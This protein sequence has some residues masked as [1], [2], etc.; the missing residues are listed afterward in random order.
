MR[1]DLDFVGDKFLERSLQI[2][3]LVSTTFGTSDQLPK[4][5]KKGLEHLDG[6]DN[7][8]KLVAYSG[9]WWR[10]EVGRNMDQSIAYADQLM[11]LLNQKDSDDERHKEWQD[12][13]TEQ[14]ITEITD[15]FL[16]FEEA[17]GAILS[18]LSKA[19]CVSLQPKPDSIKKYGRGFTYKQQLQSLFTT[20]PATDR[21]EIKATKG[22]SLQGTWD[23]VVER[24]EFKKLRGSANDFL[25]ISGGV[26]TGKTML[27][28]YLTEHIQLT[29]TSDEIL[30]YYFFDANLRL[31]NNGQC[32]VRSLIYQLVL[33]DKY[34]K[35]RHRGIWGTS[36]FQL[37]WRIFVEIL[38][39]IKDSGIVC[40][41]DGLDECEPKSL[42]LLLRN[43]SNEVSDLPIKFVV[44]SREIPGVLES[45]MSNYP[46][47]NLETLSQYDSLKKYIGTTVLDL[48]WSHQCSVKTRQGIQELV[49]RHSKG[50][51]LWA[52]LALQSLRSVTA[53]EVRR[54]VEDLPDELDAL[55]DWHLRRVELDKRQFVRE[56]LSWCAFSEEPIE[57]SQLA[58]VLPPQTDGSLA[59]KEALRNRLKH[60]GP[61]IKVSKHPRKFIFVDGGCMPK[62]IIHGDYETVTLVHRT[63]FNFLIPVSQPESWFSLHN[64]AVNHLQLAIKCLGSLYTSRYQQKNKPGVQDGCN[65]FG[66]Y[67]SKSWSYHF[68]RTGEHAVG[69]VKTHPEYFEES[70]WTNK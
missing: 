4:E 63:F 66:E 54:Y 22:T 35:R 52:A 64:A 56:V 55:Y 45:F 14:K 27:A 50:S 24:N 1:N 23:W 13:A 7:L 57:L 58:E 26:G 61:L 9:Y 40:V 49:H 34:D 38:Q 3:T 42:E 68:Q 67:A 12:T 18:D 16:R 2:R 31:R 5:L 10:D 69:L 6:L 65:F 51:Y 46:R 41:L 17:I 30:L 28:V 33:L 44:L 21:D 29:Q 48:P 37:L 59:S 25:W 70:R 36:R 20:D 15:L 39:D 47:I 53:S 60:Y 19:E 62:T 32:L 43:F 8:M 11:G